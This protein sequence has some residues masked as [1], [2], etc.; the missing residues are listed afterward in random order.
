MLGGGF[1]G[2]RPLR[3]ACPMLFVY[4]TRKPFMF[5]APAWAE[6]LAAAPGCAVQGLRTGHWVMT[7][8]PEAFNRIVEDWLD[9]RG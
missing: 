9:G 7:A 5:H 8:E 4:G 2:A 3:A 1:R 6:R